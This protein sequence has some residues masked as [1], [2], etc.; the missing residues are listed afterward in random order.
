MSEA[1]GLSVEFKKQ[2][3]SRHAATAPFTQGGHALAAA[4]CWV[5]S[6]AGFVETVRC[7]CEKRRFVV[8][9]AQKRYAEFEFFARIYKN[10][11]FE[12]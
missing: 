7:G 6:R 2:S 3:L 12:Y 11:Y 1:E 5:K 9:N 4:E 8:Q 10:S